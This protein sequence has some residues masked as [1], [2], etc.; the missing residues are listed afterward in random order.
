MSAWP[1]V[2][3]ADGG[4]VGELFNSVQFISGV[5]LALLLRFGELAIIATIPPPSRKTLARNEG[6]F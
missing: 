2:G 3:W 5:L 4:V 1:L 6:R